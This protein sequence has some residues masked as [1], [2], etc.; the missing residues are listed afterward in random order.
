MVTSRYPIIRMLNILRQCPRT[1]DVQFVTIR[2]GCIIV[3][4]IVRVL[5]W[6]LAVTGDSI[7][8]TEGEGRVT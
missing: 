5:V 1:K 8:C 2:C 7:G 3:V 6:L 4:M